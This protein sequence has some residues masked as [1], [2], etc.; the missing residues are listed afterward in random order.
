M[1][2]DDSLKRLGGG[3]WETRDGRFAIEPQSGTWVVVDN[4][5]TDD[6]G[7][8]LVRGPFGSLTAAR[9]AIEGARNAGPATS[10]L[11]G[12]IEEA[13]KAGPK[14]SKPA[15][16]RSGRAAARVAAEKIGSPDASLDA[17]ATP[18]PPPE[19]KWLLDLAPARRR[20]ARELLDQLEQLGI[21][22]PHEIVRVEIERDQP[23][24]A[25]LAIERRLR[26]I[27]G[28]AT[29]PREAVR[30]AARAIVAGRDSELDVRWRLV[31]DRGRPL[32]DLDL[33]D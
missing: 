29:D 26:V 22:E 5:Q 19:P 15:T 31:D 11:A 17:A 23:A 9:E 18:Q 16:S 2:A 6:L 1:P 10:P 28:S 27:L 4:T 14:A 30:A 33:M 13:R 24:L 20:R 25:R 12:R 7:L 3:R 21:A 32:D 8:P